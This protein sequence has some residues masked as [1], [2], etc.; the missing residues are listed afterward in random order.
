MA[1]GQLRVSRADPAGS[2]LNKEQTLF[3]LGANRYLLSDVLLQLVLTASL[4]ARQPWPREAASP[5]TITQHVEGRAARHTA[6][7]GP[8]RPGRRAG[9]GRGPGNGFLE[10]PG[11]GS[12]E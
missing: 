2:H 4:R 7:G 11:N 12:E 5:P 8:H 10:E 9:G 6:A 3:P 1:E